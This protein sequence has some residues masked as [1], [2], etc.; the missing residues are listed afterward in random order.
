[1]LDSAEAGV[2][3]LPDVDVVGDAHASRFFPLDDFEGHCRVSLLHLLQFLCRVGFRDL[4]VPGACLDVHQVG[5]PLLDWETEKISVNLGTESRP[6][7]KR[8][9]L[10]SAVI[11][12]HYFGK[13]DAPAGAPRE[14]VGGGLI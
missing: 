1:M 13:F 3:S 5:I 9:V 6:G 12:N 11:L 14:I 10:V 2:N 7:K 8:S 4:P